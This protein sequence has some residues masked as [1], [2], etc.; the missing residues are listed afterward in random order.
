MCQR[1]WPEITEAR[2][3][4]NVRGEY[5]SR[6]SQVKVKDSHRNF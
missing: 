1:F 2:L 5:G 4:I 3:W 6:E